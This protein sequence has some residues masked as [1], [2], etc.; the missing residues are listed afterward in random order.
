MTVAS[1]SSQD[2]GFSE[3]RVKGLTCLTDSGAGNLEATE[4][5]RHKPWGIMGMQPQ[6]Q[7]QTRFREK[8]SGLTMQQFSSATFPGQSSF[9]WVFTARPQSDL[10]CPWFLGKDYIKVC[11]ANHLAPKGGMTASQHLGFNYLSFQGSDI[12]TARLLAVP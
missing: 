12:N 4:M 8:V 6:I 7:Q 5:K 2:P 3:G 9:A 1:Q 11:L 10:K